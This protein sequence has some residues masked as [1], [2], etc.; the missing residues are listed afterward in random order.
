[1]DSKVPTTEAANKKC[2]AEANAAQNHGI[3]WMSFIDGPKAYI[4]PPVGIKAL[5][6]ASKKVGNVAGQQGF[7][8]ATGRN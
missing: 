4:I 5:L 3:L 1:M 2:G 6:R 7:S 8:D